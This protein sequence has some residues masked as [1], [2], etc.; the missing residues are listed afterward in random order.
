MLD[1]GASRR[2]YPLTL[3]FVKFTMSYF[4][5]PAYHT[6]LPFGPDVLTRSPDSLMYHSENGLVH[7]SLDFEEGIILG[8]AAPSKCFNLLGSTEKLSEWLSKTDDPLSSDVEHL[9]CKAEL[10]FKTLSDEVDVT[11]YFDWDF[12]DTVGPLRSFRVIPGIGT[13]LICHAVHEGICSVFPLPKSMGYLISLSALDVDFHVGVMLGLGSPVP[14]MN[15]MDFTIPST[16]LGFQGFVTRSVAVRASSEMN[17]TLYDAC[18]LAY[19]YIATFKDRIKASSTR[20]ITSDADPD[21]NNS[22]VTVR[23][24]VDVGIFPL[25]GHSGY[26]A[27][28]LAVFDRTSR[29]FLGL[30][31]K[32]Y[33]ALDY[34]VESLPRAYTTP[35]SAFFKPIRGF[36]DFGKQFF[37]RFAGQSIGLGARVVAVALSV[38]RYLFTKKP[39]DLLDA[40]K[41]APKRSVEMLVDE[42]SYFYKYAK[43]WKLKQRFASLNK[44]DG[45]WSATKKVASNVWKGRDIF[46]N[47]A[48][49]AS[50]SLLMSFLRRG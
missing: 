14:L 40:V 31:E 8:L 23:A 13:T 44:D 35:F 12:K 5:E 47:V 27:K 43:S 48:I 1:I 39:V 33:S 3:K 26:K 21:D 7:L 15:R 34:T 38:P 10:V 36:K 19:G 49:F 50:A 32:V 30:S 25:V 22:W 29:F 45:W 20:L 41:A 46:A 6:E 2:T 9:T 4:F 18:A 28:L 37:Y 42:A 11:E 17:M 16:I 24:E